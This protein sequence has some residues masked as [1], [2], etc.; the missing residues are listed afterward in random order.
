[1]KK[2]L[3]LIV[4]GLVIISMAVAQTGTA[5]PK[6]RNHLRNGGATCGQDPILPTDGSTLAFDYTYPGAATWYYVHLKGGHSYSVDVWDSVDTVIGGQATLT[7]MATDC[8]SN[9]PTT[10]V[11]SVDPDLSNDFGAR[12]SWIQSADSDAYISVGTT[13]P[14]G[15]TYS[16]RVTDTTLHSTRWSTWSGFGTQYALVN[17][18]A[19]AISGVLT[20]TESTGPQHTLNVTLPANG[21]AFRIVVAS[22]G[23]LNVGASKLG[24]AQFAFVGPPGAIMADAVIINA[25]ATV[26][27]PVDFG[28]R[29]Y[30]H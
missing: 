20:V 3:F 28:P 16:I 1:M 14:S 24:F 10:D 29:N 13:D 11:T 26:I 9:L 12:I 8:Q 22:G 4:C 18:T 25:T 21:E 7:L 15:S 30:Q 2:T 6:P 23:D 17:T 27:E 5:A 19:T